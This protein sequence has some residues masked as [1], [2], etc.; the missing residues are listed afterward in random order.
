MK[1]ARDLAESPLIVHPTTTV[2]DLARLLLDARAD[3]ACVVESNALIGVVTT[4]DLVYREAEVRLPNLV[5][6]LDAVF[7]FGARD[8]LEQ[9]LA[10][11]GSATVRDLMTDEPITVGPDATMVEVATLMVRRHLTIIPVLTGD[12]LNG[13]VTKRS[14]VLGSGL[15]DAH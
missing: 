6:V 3:G 1:T 4:M 10:K 15:L 12:V 8:S 2:R 5:S 13:V 9:E 11:I 7:S 14:L